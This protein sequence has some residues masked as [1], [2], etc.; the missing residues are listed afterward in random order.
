[1]KVKH[2]FGG[3]IV[4]GAIAAALWF[5]IARP[6]T[7]AP[8]ITLTTI[9][10]ER[11]ALKTLQ[12]KPVI[13]A[14]WATDCP[15]CIEEIPDLIALYDD[16]HDRG[17]EIIA[18][19][20]YYDPPNHVVEM[21]RAKRIPYRVALDLRAEHARAF[22]N[23]RLIP[24]TFLIEADGTIGL[25]HVGAFDPADIRQRIEAALE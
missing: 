20:M 22:G 23:V 2:W 6:A 17:L 3:T 13:V 11:I 7:P 5:A 19:A 1:M 16:F 14:F 12:G 18:V 21:T 8:D 25:H 15:V 4:A 10:G 24:T 9:T